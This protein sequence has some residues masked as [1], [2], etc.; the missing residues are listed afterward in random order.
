V[1]AVHPTA[2]VDPAAELG[3]DVEI[4]PYT[5]IG[6]DVVVGD[7]TRI[8]SHVNVQ[9]P[10]TIG[11]DCRIFFSSALGF[12]P[13]DLK[14]KGERTSLQ[15][16]ERNVVRE[17]VTL[18]RG[19]AASGATRIGDG[20]LLMAYVHVAHDCTIGHG[21]VLANAVT[22]A[23]HVTI[24]DF[25]VIGGLVPIHQFVRVGAYAFVGG[26]CRL[27]KDVPPY[28]KVAGEPPRLYGL[29][30]VGLRRHNFDDDSLATLKHAHRLLCRSGLNTAQAVERIASE[31]PDTPEVQHLLRFIAETKRGIVK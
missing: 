3:E 10:A 14:Y 8:G 24:E 7:R 6:P 9:G 18:N 22:L 29:N 16:G 31:L 30:S 20:N 28:T 17:F 21:N 12:P 13:Q 26:A 27:M 5:V 1:T 25:T 19:T 23:G 11:A 2:V 15:L 4:G